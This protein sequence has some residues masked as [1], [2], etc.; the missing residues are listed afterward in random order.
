MLKTRDGYS[1]E[2]FQYQGEKIILQRKRIPITSRKLSDKEVEEIYD[3]LG[4]RY[5]KYSVFKSDIS[6]VIYL[7]EHPCG[8]FYHEGRMNFGTGVTINGK[9]LLSWVSM[10]HTT[11]STERENEIS[12]PYCILD[13][14]IGSSMLFFESESAIVNSHIG[15]STILNGANFI[16]STSIALTTLKGDNY[17][18]GSDIENFFIANSRI[19]DACLKDFSEPLILVDADIRDNKDIFEICRYNSDTKR[20]EGGILYRMKNNAVALSMPDHGVKVLSSTS[21]YPTSYSEKVS[22]YIKKLYSK[23]ARKQRELLS[24]CKGFVDKMYTES[25]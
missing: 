5:H 22:F 19:D 6:R 13:S 15:C 25:Q 18:Y 16:H 21:Y 20:K 23:D 12:I 10:H 7:A 11:I 3:V 14:E 24:A 9:G 1:F 4:S 2:D 17:L 8:S